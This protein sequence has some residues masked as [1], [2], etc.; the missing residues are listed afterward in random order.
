MVLGEDEAGKTSLLRGIQAGRPAPTAKH[1][2]T[3]LLD[4]QQ[5]G[6]ESIAPVQLRLFDI[7]GQVWRFT[8]SSHCDSSSLG[9]LCT[10]LW[11]TCHST[12]KKGMWSQQVQFWLD[13]L[14]ADQ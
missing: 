7:G 2:R 8:S 9:G 11:W 13:E 14:Q 6:P 1:E 4:V 12:A 10:C 5:W 3:E